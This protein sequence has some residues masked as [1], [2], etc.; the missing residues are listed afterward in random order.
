[1]HDPQTAPHSDVRY[2][3]SDVQVGSILAFGLGLTVAVVLVYLGVG[4]LFSGLRQEVRGDDTPLP[5]LAAKERI[6]LPADLS[7][8]PPPLLQK[9]EIADMERSRREDEQR[10]DGYGWVDAQA[11]VAYIPIAEAMRLLA[12][13][14]IAAAQGIRVDAPAKK[15]GAK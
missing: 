15:G 11:G 2:E 3:K 6:H 7:R 1:M 9:N 14:K 12:D 4:W 13:P 5:A 8:I 10:L